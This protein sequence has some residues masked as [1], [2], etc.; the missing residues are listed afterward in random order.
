MGLLSLTPKKLINRVWDA[1]CWLAVHNPRLNNRPANRALNNTCI[2]RLTNLRLK[3]L[4][5]GFSSLIAHFSH[6]HPKGGGI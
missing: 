3:K 6:L 4:N 5:L 1:I 2:L